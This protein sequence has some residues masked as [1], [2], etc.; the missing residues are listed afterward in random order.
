MIAIVCD[1]TLPV[2]KNGA[3]MGLTMQNGQQDKGKITDPVVRPG[4]SMSNPFSKRF[5]EINPLP[6]KISPANIQAWVKN[7]LSRGVPREDLSDCLLSAGADLTGRPWE[8]WECINKAQMRIFDKM[9]ERN[10]KALAFEKSGSPLKA[11]ELYEAN[12]ADRFRGSGPYE[13]LRVLYSKRR[14]YANALRVCKMYLKLAG[15]SYED[16]TRQKFLKHCEKLEGKV[17]KSG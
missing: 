11:I 10:A 3:D 15:R 1:P 6:L 8:E 4:E 2:Q 14:D 7:E 16:L 5:S 13:R 12:L 9:V 17:A